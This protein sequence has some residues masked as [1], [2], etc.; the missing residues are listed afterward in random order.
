MFVPCVSELML[1]PGDGV[2]NNTDFSLAFLEVIVKQE[3][4][5]KQNNYI[6]YFNFYLNK[7]KD[8]MKL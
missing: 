5:I 7:Y 3:T 2:N 8:G 1:N 4:K 6:K